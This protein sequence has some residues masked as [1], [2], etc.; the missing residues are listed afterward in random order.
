MAYLLKRHREAIYA[1]SRV[2][3][4]HYEDLTAEEKAVSDSLETTCEEIWKEAG[5]LQRANA[6]NVRRYLQT[7]E[8]KQKNRQRVKEYKARKRE[9]KKGELTNDD[10][11]LDDVLKSE[12]AA[13]L[14]INRK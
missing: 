11:H 10:H 8:G 6:E 4:A 9:E 1:A 2:L 7:E 5:K 14:E 12:T 3:K 13:F